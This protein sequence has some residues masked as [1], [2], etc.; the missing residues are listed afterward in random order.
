MT[1]QR[2]VQID[3]DTGERLDFALVSVPRQR[4]RIKEWWFMVFQDGLQ[5]LAADGS[6]T[7]RQL[8]VLIFLMSRLSFENYIHVAQTEIAQATGIGPSHVSEA[9]RVLVQKGIL[10]VGPKVGRVATLRLSDTFGWKGRVRSLHDER[11]RRLS[12]AVNN[13]ARISQA[14]PRAGKAR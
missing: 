7:A 9:V 11:Q 10:I 4:A 12:I 14:K 3:A 1:Q 5:R 13:D 2:V 8:R 6:L